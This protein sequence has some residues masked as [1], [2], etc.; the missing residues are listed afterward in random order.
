MVISLV[1][2]WDGLRPLLK[3]LVGCTLSGEQRRGS[4]IASSTYFARGVK[5]LR[6]AGRGSESTD[7]NLPTRGESFS[8]ISAWTIGLFVPL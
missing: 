1:L 2:T 7:Y 6:M 8:S 3:D 5:A 4:T